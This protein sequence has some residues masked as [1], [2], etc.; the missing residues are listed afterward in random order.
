MFRTES[1][2]HITPVLR[3][4]HWLPNRPRI[5]YKILLITNKALKGM[6]P[7]YLADSST[8]STQ[9][10]SKIFLKNFGTHSDPS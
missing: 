1:V 6:A 4:L 8:L 2:E 9:Q 3:R 7:K 10:G 5:T